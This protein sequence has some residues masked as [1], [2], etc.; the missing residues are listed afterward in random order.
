MSVWQQL[1]APRN[2]RENRVAKIARDLERERIIELLRRAATYHTK[3]ARVEESPPR[4]FIAA[5]AIKEVIA[6]IEGEEQ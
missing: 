6:V 3:K 4:K 1:N 2:K 5:K